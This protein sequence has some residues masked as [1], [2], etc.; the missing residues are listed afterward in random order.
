MAAS[1]N[2]TPVKPPPI[3]LPKT[4]A[5]CADLYYTT[6]QA[7]LAKDKEAAELKAAESYIAEHLIQN[8]PKGEATGISGKLCSVRVENKKTFRVTDWD[9]L[10]TYVFKN[11]SKG[12]PAL[13][14]RRIST[15]AI[16]DI[17]N[18]GKTV[19]GVESYGYP[20]VRY[21]KL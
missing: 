20:V 13:L 6:M 2:G 18:S 9:K 5:A 7:R 21:S 1:T 4:L 11:K 8:L 15:E 17:V 12:S 19:D 16:Q 10:W 14:Q 3:K